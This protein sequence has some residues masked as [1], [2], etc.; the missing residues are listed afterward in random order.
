MFVSIQIRI[1]LL[2]SVFFFM[3]KDY[4]NA[5]MLFNSE[6]IVYPFEISSHY[7]LIA[8]VII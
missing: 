1:S 4:E 2:F 5:C 3:F 6:P 7:Y 8:C